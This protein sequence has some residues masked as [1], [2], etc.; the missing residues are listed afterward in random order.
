[1]DFLQPATAQAFALYAAG[2]GGFTM[3]G[4]ARDAWSGQ[5]Q[6][7]GRDAWLAPLGL[8][9]LAASFGAGADASVRL[10]AGALLLTGLAILALS[11]RRADRPSPGRQVGVSFSWAAIVTSLV[12]A[13][14]FVPAASDM[15]T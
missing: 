8:A 11:S 1:M 7:A 10:M 6:P 2:A 13:L 3:L 9:A 4:L 5:F 12:S 14:F 15:A